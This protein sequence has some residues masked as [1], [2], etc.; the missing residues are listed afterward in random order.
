MESPFG[1][2]A[3]RTAETTAEGLECD[4]NLV[5]KAA[6]G[7]EGT[8]SNFERGSAVGNMLSNSTMCSGEIVCERKSIDAADFIVV[9]F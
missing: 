2:A 1:E 5:D 4:V 6:A 7:L 8:E 3:V 9:L